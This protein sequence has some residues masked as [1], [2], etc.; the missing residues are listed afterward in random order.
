MTPY[1][2]LLSHATGA[3]AVLRKC[4]EK[5]RWSQGIFLSARASGLPVNRKQRWMFL[6]RWDFGVLLLLLGIRHVFKDPALSRACFARAVG[7][8][9]NAFKGARIP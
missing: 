3:M 6:S 9:L 4:I 2:G 7:K 1:S 8:L 5:I